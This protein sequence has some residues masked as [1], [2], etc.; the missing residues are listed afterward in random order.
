ML[1]EVKEIVPP[2]T[3]TSPAPTVITAFA[4]VTPLFVNVPIYDPSSST[5]VESFLQATIETMQIQTIKIQ[6]KKCFRVILKL[7]LEKVKREFNY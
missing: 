6:V 3:D 5:G 1:I 7:I 4:V 2:G